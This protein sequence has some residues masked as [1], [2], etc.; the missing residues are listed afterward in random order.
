MSNL[1]NII[2]LSLEECLLPCF[3]LK[4]GNLRLLFP[5]YETV[6]QFW[7]DSVQKKWAS[8][9]CKIVCKHGLTGCPIHK[10]SNHKFST[11]ATFVSKYLAK[12]YIK[13][14]FLKPKLQEGNNRVLKRQNV[15]TWIFFW[16]R[17]F[18]IP[19]ILENLWKIIGEHGYNYI[20]PHC[21][22]FCIKIVNNHLETFSLENNF[23]WLTD[24]RQFSFIPLT[25][26]L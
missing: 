9:H 22:T 5:Q 13:K 4:C 20:F 15:F 3:V 11:F 14:T 23:P 2:T 18:K 7:M 12:Y 1:V 10:W 16:N 25:L 17:A 24:C 8:F 6:F 19:Q 26:Q 21:Q